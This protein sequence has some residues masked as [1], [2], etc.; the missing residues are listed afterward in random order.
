MNQAKR[1][2]ASHR[3]IAAISFGDHHAGTSQI[4]PRSKAMKKR[5]PNPNGNRLRDS[6]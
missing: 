3:N 2:N 5:D 1:T 4:K 6:A